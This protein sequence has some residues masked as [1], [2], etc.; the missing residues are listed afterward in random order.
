MPRQGSA[1]LGAGD[2]VRSLFYLRHTNHHPPT[3]QNDSEGSRGVWSYLDLLED[4]G[5]GDH[6]HR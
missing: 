6:P 3:L 1:V 5:D 4:E 2:I